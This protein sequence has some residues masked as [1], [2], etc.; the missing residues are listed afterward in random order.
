[1]VAKQQYMHCIKPH[2]YMK[3]TH[4]SAIKRNQ[5]HT[6]YKI[7]G[8]AANIKLYTTDMLITTLLM[9]LIASKRGKEAN[10]IY[11]HS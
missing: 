6:H 10:L 2:T 8:S 1:M 3:V 5:S 11:L 9:N 4:L 7:T